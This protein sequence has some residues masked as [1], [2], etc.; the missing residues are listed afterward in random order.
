MPLVTLCRPTEPNRHQPKPQPTPSNR[1][2]TVTNRHPQVFLHQ[3]ELNEVYQG[4][5][6]SYALITMIT[7]LLKLHSSR[8]RP[9]PDGADG[10]RRGGGAGKRPAAAPV[11][12]NL[13]VLLLDFFR[14]YGREISYWDVG[15]SAAGAGRFFNK[16]MREG[17]QVRVSA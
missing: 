13:G 4:G 17:F 15:V 1:L 2:P 3:R 5:I 7:A 10:G 9:D 11:E 16:H 8:R 6:G 12:S 14:L